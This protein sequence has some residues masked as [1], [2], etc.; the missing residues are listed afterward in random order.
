MGAHLRTL[1]YT[2]VK[3]IAAYSTVLCDH[4]E[5]YGPFLK[6]FMLE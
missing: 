1:A 3:S 5:D 6:H 2:Q 4:Y